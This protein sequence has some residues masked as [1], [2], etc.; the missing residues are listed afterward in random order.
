LPWMG[1][2]G[3]LPQGAPE[4]PAWL[5][6]PRRSYSILPDQILA[7]TPD[8]IEA[9]C[10]TED[11]VAACTAEIEVLGIPLGNLTGWKTFPCTDSP[12]ECEVFPGECIRKQAS[13]PLP[14]HLRKHTDYLW[15]RNPFELGALAGVEGKRQFAGSDYSVPYWNARRYG[16]ITAGEGQ[17]LA[18]KSLG[19][20]AD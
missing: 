5:D 4:D 15:Q 17:V 20:C 2:N 10:P 8:G 16:F 13:G 1:G 6:E 18:W 3:G 12:W 19:D 11:E 7:A 14:V 9:V